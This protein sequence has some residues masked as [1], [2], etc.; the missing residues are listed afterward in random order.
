MSYDERLNHSEI[1]YLY[2]RLD[3]WN[4]NIS[5]AFNMRSTLLSIYIRRRLATLE[6][7]AEL[8]QW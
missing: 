6:Q 8:E 1:A 2:M 3:Y 5:A 7:L 4:T